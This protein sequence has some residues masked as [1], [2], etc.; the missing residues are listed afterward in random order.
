M[1]LI[2]FEGVGL[3]YGGANVAHDVS[4]SVN[5]GEFWGIVGEN[6]SGKTTLMKALLGLIPCASGRIVFGEGLK[7]NEIGY[8]PQQ[9][10]IQKDFPASVGEVVLSGTIGWRGMKPFYGK[11]ERALA[12]KNMEMLGILPIEKQSYQELSGGQQQRVLLARALCAAE[13]ALLLDEPVSGLDPKV[14]EDMYKLIDHLNRDDGLTIIM[15]SHDIS[16]VERAGKVLHVGKTPFFGTREEYLRSPAARGF[17]KEA[18][19]E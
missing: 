9:S 6:G 13:K 16:A 12:R 5:A 10:I 19:A 18:E 3:S 7:P 15:I 1:S 2:T 8:L 11:H 4:F 17:M 14:T